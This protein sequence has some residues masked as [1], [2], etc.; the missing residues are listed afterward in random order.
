VILVIGVLTVILASVVAYALGRRSGILEAN[1]S[2]LYPGVWVQ[3]VKP[4]RCWEGQR[5]R[6]RIIPPGTE[7]VITRVDK[8]GH[9]TLWI[10]KP[11]ARDWGVFPEA[12]S[13]ENLAALRARPIARGDGIQKSTFEAIAEWESRRRD[14]GDRLFPPGFVEFMN[15]ISDK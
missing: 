14:L 12:H 5:E 9:L 15:W 6:S 1:R 8:W 7:A 2:A 3:V 4:L 11:W 13:I 10:G